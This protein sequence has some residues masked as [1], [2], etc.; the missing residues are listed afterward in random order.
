MAL[1]NMAKAG[2]CSTKSEAKVD[3]YSK[4]SNTTRNGEEY[5]ET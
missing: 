3:N 1:G 2:R 4:C 5:V